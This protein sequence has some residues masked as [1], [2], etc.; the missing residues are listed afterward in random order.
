[1]TIELYGAPTGYRVEI[2][3]PIYEDYLWAEGMAAQE[4]VDASLPAG[5]IRELQ[6]ARD[7]VTMTVVRRVYA[8]DGTEVSTD[9]FVSQY[10]PQGPSYVVSPDMAGSTQDD[11]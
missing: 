1:L 7:G 2:D 5:T 8:A 11:L 3:D 10:E 4:S 6:P 9:T